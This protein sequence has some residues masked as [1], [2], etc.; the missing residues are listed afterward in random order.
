MGFIQCPICNQ[1]YKLNERLRAAAGKYMRCKKCQKK[2]EVIIPDNER[3][4]DRQ[5]ACD[6][7][8]SNVA[9]QSINNEAINN[10]TEPATKQTAFSVVS[11]SDE[12]RMDFSWVLR[13]FSWI[14]EKNSK[15]K[16]TLFITAGVLIIFIFAIF[17]NHNHIYSH[18]SFLQNFES[19]ELVLLEGGT[20]YKD[21]KR[22]VV[23]Q[24][25]HPR[26]S[27]PATYGVFIGLVLVGI[28]FITRASSTHKNV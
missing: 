27:I 28:G 21:V 12:A 10:T 3:T 25:D 4:E 11:I 14:M 23:D 22:H 15:S 13:G 26:I 16:G 5:P 20:E 8:L 17:S 7:K 19:M 1:Q 18:R 2:F 24:I 9:Q 6:K